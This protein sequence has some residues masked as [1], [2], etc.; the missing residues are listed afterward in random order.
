MSVKLF[1]TKNIIGMGTLNRKMSY[2]IK[3]GNSLGMSD[4]HFEARS[5]IEDINQ[6]NNH[7]ISKN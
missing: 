4:D 7:R 3:I 2:L 1:N 6:Q 5:P